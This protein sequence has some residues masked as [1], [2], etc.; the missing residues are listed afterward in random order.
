M[1]FYLNFLKPEYTVPFPSGTIH[2]Y[3]FNF[4][5]VC[6]FFITLSEGEKY[7][8][9]LRSRKYKVCPF[10]KLLLVCLCKIP[11]FLYYKHRLNIINSWYKCQKCIKNY[12]APNLIYIIYVNQWLCWLFH[13][14][15]CRSTK[16]ALSHKE[17]VVSKITKNILYWNHNF[18]H[19]TKVF[20]F[21]GTFSCK[22]FFLL[23]FVYS[24]LVFDISRRLIIIFY[25]LEK[26]A[27]YT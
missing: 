9:L 3:P 11:Y 7:S 1:W 27:H 20:R 16:Y 8:T 17:L 23:S 18:C 24:S 12:L 4:N 22:I 25:I 5:I 10:A 26:K 14:H 2:S 15:Q 13:N 19:K 6:I 21:N